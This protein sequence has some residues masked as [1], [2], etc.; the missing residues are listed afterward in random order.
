MKHILSILVLLSIIAPSIC[1]ADTASGPKSVQLTVYNQNFALV[2]DTRS[3]TLRKG[4][5]N[6]DAQDVAARIDPTSILFKSLTAPNSVSILEQNYQYDLISPDSILNKSIGEQVTFTWY[7]G[8]GNFHQDMGELI[9]TP[10]NGGVVIQKDDGNIILRPTGQTTLKKMPEGLHPKPTLNW[11]L[12]SDRAGSQDTE[13]S[14]ITDGIGWKCDYVALVNKDD[15]ALDLTGWVTLNNN[16]GATYKDA[17]L[18]LMAGDVRRLQQ[19]GAFGGRTMAAY[20]MDSMASKPQ[21]EE[22][23]FFEYHMYSMQRPTTIRDNETKQLSLLNA[24]NVPTKKEM[25]YDARGDWFR[26]WWYPT[27]TDYDPGGGY[28]TSNYHKV[29]VVL[30][31]VNS[32]ENHMG[33]PL[34]KGK[35]RVYKLDDSGS[36][37][38]IGEDSIDHTP[39]D[40]KVRLYIG[41]AFDVVG[42]YKR[43]NY[44]K[45]TDRIIEESFEVKIRNHKETAVEVKVV[46]HVWSEWSVTKSTHKFNKK[47]AHTIEFPVHVAANGETVITYTIRTR[48]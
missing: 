48:W 8:A 36:Q 9:S 24:A 41:D 39:K 34:P 3:V 22:K 7:D 27:R 5:N 28:D 43:T 25:I 42:D 16:S 29:N 38:F 45:I 6:I 12:D 18:T 1:G 10:A 21:F 32:K 44:D 26:N 30:E 15:S 23:S 33:I 20:A 35:I 2:K 31:V 4:M 13:I 47:D 17:K 40:E 46:D 14:Y 37:Q 11:L 19:E